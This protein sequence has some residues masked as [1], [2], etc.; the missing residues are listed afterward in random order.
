MNLI[1]CKLNKSIEFFF[2]PEGNSSKETFFKFRAVKER[3]RKSFF[4]KKHQV[5]QSKKKQKPV[6]V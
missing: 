3:E 5:S 6:K 2:F 1:K 4:S